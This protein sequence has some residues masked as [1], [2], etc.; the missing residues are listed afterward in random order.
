MKL[1]FSALFNEK[2]AAQVAAFFLF[3]ANQ[4]RG[5]LTILKL[6][7]LMYLAE[8]HSYAQYGESMTGDAMVS[9]PHGPVLS[10]TLDLINFGPRG[11]A[12]DGGWDT[13]ISERSGRDMALKDPSLIRSPEK[14]LKELSESDL[15]VLQATW[16]SHGHKSAIALEAYTHDPNNCPEWED[17]DGSS[18]PIRLEKLL[19]ALN[20][21]KEEAYELSARM[22]QR[23][24]VAA[25]L[26]P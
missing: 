17:P 2:K 25:T 19:S 24:W 13:W 4:K 14:D 6:M 15:E 26:N 12:Q 7:K 5:N 3:K 8:R 22:K 9:M 21:S 18:K 23:A 20:F 16:D 10:R 1:K 11:D